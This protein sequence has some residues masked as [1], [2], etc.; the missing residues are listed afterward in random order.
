MIMLVVLL[1]I[2]LLIIISIIVVNVLYHKTNAYKNKLLVARNIMN[3]IPDHIKFAIF[4]STYT[5]YAFNSYK[6]LELDGCFSF[7]M[8]AQSLEI[9]NVLLHKYANC[10]EENATVVFSLA[11]CVSLYRYK[12]VA[13]KQKYY[14]FLKNSELPYYS[15]PDATYRFF[16]RCVGMK[17]KLKRIIKDTDPID[18]VVEV[19]PPVCPE[20]EKRNN[21]AGMAKGWVILFHLNDLKSS[22]INPENQSNLEFNANLL[23]SM[24]EFCV[25][26]KW[27]PVFVITPFSAELNQ[28]FGEEFVQAVLY[29]L[30]E[31]ARAK[32]NV[33]VYDYRTHESFQNDDT[34][35]IDGGFRMS[36]YGSKKFIQ[37]LFR[38][39][40]QD[41]YNNSKIGKNEYSR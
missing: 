36:K 14:H 35:Y 26:K 13:D 33:P 2:L 37:L 31:P 11:A 32:Y 8:D 1:V 19:F 24:V 23:K 25:E 39:M 4:G 34:S 41:S 17:Q 20:E 16:S 28:Y 30:M 21:M 18:D 6:E 3:G 10:I 15:L 7:A 38:D 22:S 29:K 40:G 12:M 27:K 5:M 9:D